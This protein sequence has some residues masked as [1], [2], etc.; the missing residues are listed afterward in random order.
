MKGNVIYVDFIYRRKKV[1]YIRF[2]ITTK[3]FSFV[4][5]FKFLFLTEERNSNVNIR[6][7]NVQ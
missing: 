6:V 1:S 3:S 5:Y 4:R 7:K 2:L